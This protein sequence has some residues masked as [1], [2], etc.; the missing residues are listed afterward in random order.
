[1]AAIIAAVVSF[2]S[3]RL[4]KQKTKHDEAMDLYDKVSAD[5]DRLRK[6][7]D[8]LRK[9]IEELKNAKMDQ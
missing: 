4:S 6:E 9:R 5:N 7:N 8:D 3:Y 2:L 1:M